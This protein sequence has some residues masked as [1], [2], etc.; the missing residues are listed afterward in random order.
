MSRRCRMLVVFC[1][2]RHVG[3]SPGLSSVARVLG[4][5]F[6]RRCLAPG[7]AAELL[8]ETQE[9]VRGRAGEVRSEEHVIS[10]AGIS[11]R[12][13]AQ[14]QTSVLHTSDCRPGILRTMSR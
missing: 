12:R 1:V 13:I 2:N 3:Q 10:F 7:A 6:F 14:G 4:G 11:Q 5:F 8:L 9:Q